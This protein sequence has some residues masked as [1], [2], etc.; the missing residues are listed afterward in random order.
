MKR[1]IA[2]S[3]VVAAGLGAGCFNAWF[4]L[5][6]EQLFETELRASC[7][8]AFNCC[9]A[10]ERGELGSIAR[11]EATCVEQGLEEG[12]ELALLGQRAKAAIDAGT[13]VYDGELAERCMRP[14]LD[15]ADQ[16]DPAALFGAR[17]TSECQVG[18][19]RAFVVG[20]VDD[21]GDCVDSLE[22]ADEGD[23]VVE[24]DPDTITIA[25]TCVARAGEGDSCDDVQCKA[26]LSCTFGE[27]RATCE[28]IELRDNG[29]DCFDDSECSSG[30]CVDSGSGACAESG[31]PCATDDDCDAGNFEFCELPSSTC[32][33]ESNVDYD[34]CDGRE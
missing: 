7:R 2:S 16:C 15:A 6:P 23:C 24:E 33:A 20:Q 12:G 3:F 30:F 27:E 19:A 21:G 14:Q 17:R 32:A 31:E 9:E 29:E 11:D 10:A 18:S 4:P 28:R 22:C 13:A 1:L 34:I 25:G 8:F 5:A 26:G